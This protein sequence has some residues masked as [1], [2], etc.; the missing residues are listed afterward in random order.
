MNRK[1]S[2]K[3]IETFVSCLV[4]EEKSSATIAKYTRDIEKL[5]KYAKNR[6]ITKALMIEYKK[7]LYDTGKYKTT[8]INSFIIAANRYLEYMNW[9]DAK[10]KTFCVQ[11]DPFCAED[12][13]LS[14][15]EYK[16]L[17]NTANQQGKFRLSM[18]LQTICMTGIRIS[19]LSAITVSS[20]RQGHTEVKNKGKLR[21]II[22][23]PSLQ[24]LLLL[25]IKNEGIE[26]GIVFKTS[27]GAPLD[28]SNIWKEMKNLCIYAN[29][30][31]EKVF[32]HNLRHL[33]ALSFYQ[34]GHD[35]AKLADMLGHSSIETTRLYIKT[36]ST[37]HCRQLEEMDLI[38]ETTIPHN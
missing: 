19:E 17:V 2:Q 12:K 26:S 36:S 14:K 1:I 16:T 29:I 15:Q 22:L 32:P 4:Q 3:S 38:C 5:R 13:L 9:Q 25:Y 34:V 27:H 18:I 10:V 24:K 7:Y 8:S 6:E 20:V 31:P 21:Q 28:R 37:E 30:N 33:F 11:N 35:I 23:S